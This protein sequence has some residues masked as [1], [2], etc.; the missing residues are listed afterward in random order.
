MEYGTHGRV[1]HTDE[2]N[3]IA[4]SFYI[5]TNCSPQNLEG[6]TIQIAN[7]LVQ[8]FNELY[9]INL[10]IKFPNDITYNGKKIGGILT[11]TKLEGEN[12]KSLVIGIG[13]NTNGKNFGADIANIASSIKN[14]FNITVDNSVVIKRFL[15]LFESVLIERKIIE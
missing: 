12:V 8:V 10:G 13:I 3:N 2:E 6:I 14:E 5:K 11:Q 1:W 4:F 9:K 7:I 15:E